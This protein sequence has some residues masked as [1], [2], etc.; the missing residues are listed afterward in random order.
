MA[1]LAGESIA[2]LLAATDTS[3]VFAPDPTRLPLPAEAADVCHSGGVLEHEPPNRLAAFLRESFRV[4]RPDG[5]ASHVYDHRD[6]LRHVD[7]RWPFLLHMALPN[8][9]YRALLGHPLLFHNRLSPR[10]VKALFEDAGFEPIA[11]R[12]FVLPDKRYVEEGAER[13]GE[14]GVPEWLGS[15]RLGGLSVEDRHTAAIHYLYRKPGRC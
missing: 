4:L 10:E 13:A 11:A 9:A 14:A 12:R 1:E 3:A 8:P 6:H 15:G 5:V 7:P 2:G